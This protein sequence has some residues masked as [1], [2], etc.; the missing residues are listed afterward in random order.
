MD[1]YDVFTKTCMNLGPRYLPRRTKTRSKLGDPQTMQNRLH[2][3]TSRGPPF[4]DAKMV[5]KQQFLIRVL[6]KNNWPEILQFQCLWLARLNLPPPPGSAGQ[7][8]SHTNLGPWDQ[9]FSPRGSRRVSPKQHVD[10]FGSLQ[11]LFSGPSFSTLAF[12]SASCHF[13]SAWARGSRK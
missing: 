8:A 10:L 1:D 6:M 12:S 7:Q 13:P 11:A 3:W 4:V 9:V 2:R 5:Q